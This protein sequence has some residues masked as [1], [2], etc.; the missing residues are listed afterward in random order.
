V[1][2]RIC[3]WSSRAPASMLVENLSYGGVGT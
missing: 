1:S 3:A 2:A